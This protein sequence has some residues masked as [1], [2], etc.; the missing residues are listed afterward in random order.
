M[1]KCVMAIPWITLLKTVPWTKVIANAPTVAEG[2]KKLWKT[3]SSRAPGAETSA[4]AGGTATLSE[5]ALMAKMQAE[6]RSLR[7]TTTE[8]HQQMLAS[9][10]LIRELADQN[11]AL[12]KRVEAYRMRLLWLSGAVALLAVLVLGRLGG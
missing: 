2:A 4:P 5:D 7:I 9:S 12:I 10:E 1:E 3:V 8:L 11:T 6:L